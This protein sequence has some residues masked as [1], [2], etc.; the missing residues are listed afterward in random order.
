LLR[1][2][3]GSDERLG[4]ELAD[5]ARS[6]GVRGLLHSD[7]LPAYGVD[8]SDVDRLRAALALGPNDAFVL[9]TDPD[10]SKAEAALGRVVARATA[11]LEGIPGETRD[12]L[13]DGR[14]RF[15]RPLPGRE[16]MYPETDI[17]PIPISPEHRARLAARLPERPSALRERLTR[18]TGLAKEVVLQLVAG[19]RTDLFEELIRRRHGAPIVAR[20]LI[21][22]LPAVPHAEGEP[23]RDFAFAT[24]DELLRAEEAG[25]FAKEGIPN[26]LLELAKGAPNVTAAVAQAGLSGFTT[27]ELAVLVERVVGE[28]DAL[29]RSRGSEAFSPLMGDVM[30]QVRGRRDGQEVAEALRRSIARRQA[31]PT[32]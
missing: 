14:T 7:E 6:T 3:Q 32:A 1:A 5:A 9:V 18:E 4:R 25:A 23:E 10:P 12:P 24:L 20:L 2:P 27:E 15:S 28:N 30:R 31:D 22:D 13:P 29:V 26:V 16:R 17:P 21:Q 11:A 8:A 19:G